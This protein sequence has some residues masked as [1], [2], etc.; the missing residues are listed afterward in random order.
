MLH[1][2]LLSGRPLHPLPFAECFY[3]HYPKVAFGHWPPVFYIV[4]ALWFL[5]FGVRIAAAR[6]LCACITAGCAV[7]LYRR[8]R[9]DW[10]QWPALAV[11]ALFLALPVIR[12]QTWLVMS[13][14][15]LA[16]FVFLALCSLADCLN[17]GKTSDALWLALWSSLAILTKGTGWLLLGPI[18]AGPLVTGRIRVY[19]SRSYWLAIVL[20]GIAS[21]PFYILMARLNL[22]YPASFEWYLLR[23]R[24]MLPALL[25]LGAILALALYRFLPRKPLSPTQT[26]SAV[27]MVWG[28]VLVA[29]INLVPLTPELLR[30]YIAAAAPAAYLLA[31]AIVIVPYGKAAASVVCAGL[32]VGFIA[33]PVNSTK[34]YSQA[35]GAVPLAQGQMVLVESDSG[36]EGALIAARLERDPK[37]ST[38]LVRGTKFLEM[39]DWSGVHYTS[40]YAAAGPLR[41]ALD[42]ADPDYVVVDTS[43]PLT[44]D[45]RLL[46]EVLQG[47]ADRWQA[48]AR[49]PVRLSFRSGELLVYRRGPEG[50]RSGAPLSVQLGPERGQQT[51]SCKAQ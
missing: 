23:L 40:R 36:G 15:L 46:R 37:R 38:Y 39:S 3:V 35:M 32:L 20:I 31:G 28:L 34:A 6:W 13:D 16:G 2:Y 33:L 12:Q 21:A 50:R 49:V 43:A 41:A 25:I 5:V 42:G 22:G 51:F 1:D 26:V 19:L 7:A 45:A 44:A 4:E 10:G 30:Y 27:L 17:T 14:L 48:I 11:T 24:S 18:A 9:M 47:S 8:C 29:F